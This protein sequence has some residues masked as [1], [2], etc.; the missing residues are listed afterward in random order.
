MQE[1]TGPSLHVRYR[2]DI[3]GLRAL[4]VILVLMSHLGTQITGGYVGVDVFFVISGY[5]ISANI[6]SDMAAG[7][8]TIVGF[9]ERRVRRIFPALLAMLLVVTVLAYRYLIP[10]E[11]EDYS[12]SLL[13][14]LLSGSNFYFWHKGGYF[15]QPDLQPLLH[16]WSL[17]VEEQFYILFPL[18]LVL[19]RRWFPLRLRSAIVGISAV[20]FVAACLTV[21]SHPVA[22]FFFAPLRAWELLIGTI[23][24]Q[25]YIPSLRGSLARN[26]ASAVGLVLI[27][28]PGWRYDDLTVF[29]GLSAL[30]PCLG[31]AM[32]IAAGDTGSSLVGRLLGWRPIAFIGMISYSLYLWHWPIIV[33][34]DAGGMAMH[35]AVPARTVKIAVSLLSIA[36]AAL[37]WRF[38][39]QPFRSGKFRPGRR[40]VFAISGF[41]SLL[42]AAAAAWMLSTHGMRWRFP[43][44]ALKVADS[45]V[46]STGT[47]IGAGK[48]FLG[49]ENTFADFS[50]DVCLAPENGRPSI[51]VAGD[52]HAAMLRPG[53]AKVFPDRELMQ[54]TASDCAPLV[55]SARRDSQNCKDLLRFLFNDYLLHRRIG[56]LLLEARWRWTDLEGVE[57]TVEYAHAHDIPVVV[58]GPSIEY[59][60]PEAR[61]VVLALRDRR[62][63]QIRSHRLTAPQVLDREMA[64]LARSRWHVP[65]ISIYDDLCQPDCPVYAGDSVP[66]LFDQNHL[67]ADGATLLA[68]AIR[69]NGQ[70]P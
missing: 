37:S 11:L 4:A 31:T 58:M 63:E 41:A 20:S 17:G 51:L 65:Y 29:P 68:K 62:A 25:K 60:K 28:L 3:D 35:S 66:L 15:D 57:A 39:E 49:P 40:A 45:T 8:F 19:I 2:P 61:L 55:K 56:I 10:S 16:T 7:K 18:F 1:Q 12:R 6:L 30:P 42:L 53:L 36:A 26:L 27:L 52:S 22:A 32:I 9:Y 13:A 46:P 70:L 48:C 64:Q 50:R 34:Q 59:D 69:A 21:R 43:P 5:L 67:T 38:V 24:S 33:F 14:A 54:A 23:V 47:A 44:D